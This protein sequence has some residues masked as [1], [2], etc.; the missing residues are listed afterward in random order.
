MSSLVSELVKKGY[1]S[2]NA[3]THMST[4]DLLNAAAP[5]K[6]SVAATFGLAAIGLTTIAPTTVG[7]TT[8][9]SSAAVACAA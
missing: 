9:D 6:G 8:V 5:A 7:S 4:A 3:E 1:K 2:I